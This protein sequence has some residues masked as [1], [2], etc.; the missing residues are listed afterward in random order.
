MLERV[1]LSL[2]TAFMF[3]VTSALF[4][5]LISRETNRQDKPLIFLA[6]Y[7]SGSLAY[8]L[9]EGLKVMSNAG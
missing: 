1:I 6:T 3:I 9:F 8:F 5:A 2:L 4:Y 7:I